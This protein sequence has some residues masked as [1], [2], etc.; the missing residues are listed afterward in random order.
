MATWIRRVAV[1]W[2][3]LGAVALGCGGG[4]SGSSGGGLCT[5]YAAKLQ[6][7]GFTKSAPALS[8]EC[9]EPTDAEVKCSSAC[10]LGLSCGD[11][12]DLYCAASVSSGVLECVDKCQSPPFQC[13]DGTIVSDSSRCDGYD[14]CADAS[15]EAGC[16]TFKCANGQEVNDGAKCDGYAE[17]SD[18]SD[19]AGCP[20]F[21]C[22][23]GEVISEES[24]C[25]GFEDCS[26]GSDE[27]GCGNTY[28]A[29]IESDCAAKGYPPLGGGG[30]P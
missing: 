30:S 29:A 10:I 16:P 21:Q 15:D 3:V 24:K 20:T 6:Q 14:D 9:E 26:D 13:T 1:T 19:E 12:S 4:T 8:G 17:C 18:G 7:C 22:A 23:S 11:F 25:D 27:V 28:Q 2:L 5:Q